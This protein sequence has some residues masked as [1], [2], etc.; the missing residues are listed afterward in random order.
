[1]AYRGC[2]ICKREIEPDRA[3]TLPNTR[4]C[5]EHARMLKQYDSRGEFIRL[6]T[7]ESTSKQ[8]ILKRTGGKGVAVKLV[9]NIE[10]I[11]KLRDAYESQ[12]AAHT[13]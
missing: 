2:E 12:R 3:E 13:R 1:M 8:G 6:V 7:L 5:L 11:E 4:L 9:R 10:A